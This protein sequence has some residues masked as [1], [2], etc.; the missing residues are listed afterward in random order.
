[1]NR[2]IAITIFCALAGMAVAQTAF[3]NTG[4]AYIG[5]TVVVA[6]GFKASSASVTTLSGEGQIAIAGDFVNAVTSGHVFNYTDGGSVRFFGNAA[7][8]ISFSTGTDKAVNYIN[9]P[10]LIVDKTVAQGDS[11]VT[12]SADAAAST[13]NL[14][15]RSGRLILD[16]KASA[17]DKT[18]TNAHLKIGTYIKSSRHDK[19]TGL[20][21]NLDMGDNASKKAVSGFAAPINDMYADY[22]L[23][24][25][26]SEPSPSGLFGGSNGLITDIYARLEPGRGY[27]LG[28]GLYGNNEQLYSDLLD[29]TLKGKVN[30]DKR[31]KDKFR[32]SRA[33]DAMPFDII[34]NRNSLAAIEDPNIDSEYS[35][36]LTAG[37]NYLGNPYTAPLDLQDVYEGTASGVES[38]FWIPTSGT[39]EY[40][41]G[42]YIFN[43]SYLKAQPVG[44]T[45]TNGSTV[46][47]MQMFIVKA[48]ANGNNYV[49]RKSNLTLVKK[50]IA[51]TRAGDTSEPVDELLIETTDTKTGGFDRASIVLRSDASDEAT[52]YYDAPKLFN[53][54]GGVNQIYTRSA[55]GETLTANVLPTTTQHV[56]LYFEPAAESQQVVLR[57]S[58]LESICSI[59]SVVLE[60]MMTGKQTNLSREKEYAFNSSPTD[61]ADRFILHFTKS[62]VDN[63]HVA[64]EG[65]LI[66]SSTNEGLRVRGLITGTIVYVYN[67]VGQLLYQAK[68]A[69][70]EMLIPSFGGQGIISN[71]GRSV[72]VMSYEL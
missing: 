37:F 4:A 68:A 1:M 11:I 30:P 36:Q 33:D 12:M 13:R 35:M 63:I 52:D 22:F 53:R 45:A 64:A 21:M 40:K 38:G 24:N 62:A 14:E 51:I 16:S 32:F 15:I 18:T 58:R 70:D 67:A 57:A 31:V 42:K 2:L 59:G 28:M 9:F 6:G 49:I 44:G 7:Q 20:Q 23:F 61:R 27:L 50:Y 65:K 3:H 46:A 17:T 43:I 56:N 34:Y 71:A 10:D 41:D 66:A 5:D 47:P 55:D 26:L 25:F 54:S 72:R 8:N 19:N 29:P 60:D 48:K 39:G 69:S